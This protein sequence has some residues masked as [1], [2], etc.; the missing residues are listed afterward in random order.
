MQQ[1]LF[2]LV[3]ILVFSYFALS[4]HGA[5]AEAERT[6]LSA[7]V[8]MAG[9]H[10]ARQRLADVLAR[11]FDE[12]DE[13]RDRA[14]T[15]TSGLSLIGT[16]DA[17]ETVEA[18]FDDVDDFHGRAARPVSTVWMG[19]TLRFTDSV[20]VRYLHDVTLLEVT[21]PTLTKEVTVTVRALPVGFI[22]TPPI[23]ATLRQIVTPSS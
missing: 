18:D 20:S 22:G 2:A 11:R 8:E 9:A 23:A 14:R 16:P 19:Q 6:A 17:G 21:G 7:E 4:Q 13:D 10:L 1:T 3:A 5:T 12:A 15:S